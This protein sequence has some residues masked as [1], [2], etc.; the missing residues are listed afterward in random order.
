MMMS[1]VFE[2][3]L[4]QDLEDNPF[5]D[6][7]EWCE[8]VANF[9]FSNE[10]VEGRGNGSLGLDTPIARNEVAVILYRELQRQG[11]E[12]AGSTL[13]EFTDDIMP[14]ATEAVTKLV[15]EEIVKGFEDGSFGG[16]KSILKQDLAIMLM[17]A[18]DK[19]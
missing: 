19:M 6:V 2:W 15:A 5:T 1:R 14:W 13:I 7:P 16:E 9:A 11:Y 8:N 12:F 18:H 4:E 3:D 17:R 10:L